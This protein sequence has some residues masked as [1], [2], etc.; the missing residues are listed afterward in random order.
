MIYIKGYDTGRTTKH[1]KKSDFVI[2][3]LE[4]QECIFKLKAEV[5]NVMLLLLFFMV[6]HLNISIS[7]VIYYIMF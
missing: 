7:D 1:T 5:E 3:E 6:C 2:C 4:K